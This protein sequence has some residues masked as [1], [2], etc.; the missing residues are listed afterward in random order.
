MQKQVFQTPVFMLV[1]TIYH[2]RGT[3]QFDCQVSIII[4]YLNG[5]D[6]E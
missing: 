5:S 6:F 2:T 1:H 3:K 4:K